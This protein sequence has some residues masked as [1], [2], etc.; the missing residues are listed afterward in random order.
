[1]KSGHTALAFTNLF[2]SIFSCLFVLYIFY[3]N[4]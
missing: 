3:K 4:Q 1:L 2:V